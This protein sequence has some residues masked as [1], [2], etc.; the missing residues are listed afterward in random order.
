MKSSIVATFL[1]LA[2]TTFAV[3]VREAASSDTAWNQITLCNDFHG[4]KP[5]VTYDAKTGCR[6]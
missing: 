6:K 4:G 3:S 2:A 1:G 5:C